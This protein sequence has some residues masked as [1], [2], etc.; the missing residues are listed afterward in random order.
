MREC[1]CWWLQRVRMLGC[2]C[3]ESMGIPEHIKYVMS[4]WAL[5]FPWVH[6]AA[7]RACWGCL[8]AL[9][10]AC[11][12]EEAHCL[13]AWMVSG[14]RDLAPIE[15]SNETLKFPNPLHGAVFVSVFTLLGL[16]EWITSRSLHDP[17][18]LHPGSKPV[19]SKPRTW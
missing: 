9:G 6:D 5:L 18:Q 19:V 10:G 17:S 3:V 12:E 7:A 16:K 14:E 15:Y 2:G 13:E 4:T 11:F 8:R 1:L